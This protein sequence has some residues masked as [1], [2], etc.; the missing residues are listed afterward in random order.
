VGRVLGEV[1]TNEGSSAKKYAIGYTYNKGWLV[2][3]ANL[4]SGDVLTYT[5]GCAGRATLLSDSSNNFVGYSGNPATY[6]PSVP[7]LL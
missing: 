1:R 5:V 3:N 4:S 6:A 7:L 2:T